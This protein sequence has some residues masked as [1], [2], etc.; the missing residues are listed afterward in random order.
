MRGVDGRFIPVK[1]VTHDWNMRYLLVDDIEV[2]LCQNGGG[3]V[4]DGACLPQNFGL[5]FPLDPIESTAVNGV[6]LEAHTLSWLAPARE[7]HVYHSDVLA[8]VG[9]SVGCRTVSQ[10]P[11][12][13]HGA[14]PIDA[15]GHFIANTDGACLDKLKE[16]VLRMF[17]VSEGAPDAWSSAAGSMLH[18][19]LS[20]A[21]YDTVRSMNTEQPSTPG[22]PRLSRNEII[23][24]ALRLMDMADRDSIHVAD[25][26]R[27]TGVAS[28]TLQS[29]FMEHFGMTPYRFLMLDR[30]RRIHGA[31]QTAG[32]EDTVAG[33]CSRYGVWDFGRFAGQYQRIYGALPSRVL[34][35]SIHRNTLFH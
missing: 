34:Q 3:S 12:L 24:S 33:V 28:R 23:G 10:W 13:D 2:M 1:R 20:C 35:R 22:R 16:L 11:A 21:I 25:L 26:C 29:V 14:F 27:A 8:W 4:Y 32:P 30:L 9:I 7:F 19:Q 17:A 18:R 15:T 31:L 5:F 6:P